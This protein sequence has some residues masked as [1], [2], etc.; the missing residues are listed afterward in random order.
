[1]GAASAIQMGE[2]VEEV[3]CMM[4]EEPVNYLNSAIHKKVSERVN[5]PI[6]GESDC[7]IVDGGPYLKIKVL[8]YCSLMWVYVVALL[9]L[10]KVCIMDVCH[11]RIQAHVCGQLRQPH[12]SPLG[13]NNP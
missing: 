11:I 8:M 6:A 13:N 1:M 10:K 7:I 9:K 3:G 12:V 4:Y 5:V 2:V